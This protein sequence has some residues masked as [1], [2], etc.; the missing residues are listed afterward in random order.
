MMLRPIRLFLVVLAFAISAQTP[1][2]AQATPEAT[3]KHVAALRVVEVTRLAESTRALYQ[4]Q[5]ARVM[6]ELQSQRPEAPGRAFDIL[7][8]ELEAITTAVVEETSTVT[9]EMYQERFT[10]DELNAIAVFYESPVG[11]KALNEMRAIAASGATKGQEIGQRL[12]AVAA[13]KAMERIK[14]EGL[15]L[16]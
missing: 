10:T 2:Q 11:Q 8:D 14:S 12:G 4:Q 13:A 16:Q 6:G 1:A 3:A 7:E 15:K 5:V 9:V